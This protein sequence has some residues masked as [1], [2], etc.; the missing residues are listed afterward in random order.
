MKIREAAVAGRFYP[1]TKREITN[2]LEQIIRDEY[3]YINLDRASKKIT[4]AVV[5]HAGYM[6]SAYQAIHFFELLKLSK[7][8][9]DTFII[10]NPNH[11]GYGAEISLDE[12]DYWATPLGQVKL[13]KIFHS[14]LPFIESSEAHKYEHSG[15]VMLPL[16]QYFLDYEFEILPITLSK[17]NTD[18]A[19][20]IAQEINKANKNLKKEICIIA[21]SDFSHFVDPEEGRQLDQ[22]VIQE[23]LELNAEGVFREVT[24]KNISVCGFGPIMT[25]I[26]YSKLVTRFPKVEVLKTGH[27]GEVIPSNEVVDYASILFYE[28]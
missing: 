24:D 7:Q 12:N 18:N 11:S 27:S 6:F 3:K 14:Q 10:I 16:L 26:E 19:K 5:P 20:H 2:L 22:F 4:G 9:F 1:A 15:E 8:Q 28:D 21:S 25:L 23:I 17:Q 13:D